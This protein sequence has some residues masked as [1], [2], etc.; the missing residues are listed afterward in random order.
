MKPQIQTIFTTALFATLSL[1]TALAFSASA[2]TGSTEISINVF[3]K[4]LR[5]GD[6][7][8][9]VR[10]LQKVLN[11]LPETTLAESG[12]GA[13]GEETDYFG[14]RTFTAVIKFQEKHA[15]EI[16][17]PI[18]LSKG[19]GFVGPMTRKKLNQAAPAAGVST[20]SGTSTGSST[21]TSGSGTSSAGLGTIPGSSASAKPK[22]ISVT[23]SSIQNGDEVTI[24]GEGFTNDNTVRTSIST[25]E[26]IASPDGKTIKIKIYSESVALIANPPSAPTTEIFNMT[27]EE[28]A[29]E[30]PAGTENVSLLPGAF[31]TEL[32]IPVA[33]LVENKNGRSEQI[34]IELRPKSSVSKNTKETIFTKIVRA[35]NI[36]TKFA[37]T[38]VAYAGHKFDWFS[39]AQGV[40]NGMWSTYMSQGGGLSA[41]GTSGDCMMNP[42]P[43]FGGR[44]VMTFTCTCP[45]PGL[46]Y[47]ILPV[48]G[49]PGP[50]GVTFL[51]FGTTVKQ[52]YSIFP[53]NNV[54]GNSYGP[55]TGTCGIGILA[56][57]FQFPVARTQVV[58]TSATP[59]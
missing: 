41:G 49:M 2:Q 45:V 48:G 10:N 51:E 6:R 33:I 43:C 39:W 20:G 11:S 59:A 31:V 16:L 38:P 4:D 47:F 57:C 7:G 55:S 12:P 32:V 1:L 29:S 52:W 22:I 5:Q 3:P 34:E 40:A 46:T 9:D 13:P 54:L 24:T 50:Y 35:A 30:V 19:T 21:Q 53:G 23:P 56:W 17:F 15:D 36:V 44:V 25:H 8:E 26:H 28:I 27:P 37:Q 14:P 42:I 18:Q 58:G